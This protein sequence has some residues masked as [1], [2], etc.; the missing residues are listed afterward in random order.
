MLV[1][2]SYHH[3]FTWSDNISRGIQSVLAERAGGVQLRFEFMDTKHIYGEDH[4]QELRR[5]YTLKYAQRPV[6]V[7]IASDDRALHFMLG[8]GQE[9]FPNVPVVFCSVSGYEPSMRQGREITGAEESIDIKATLDIALHLHPGTKDVAVIADMTQTGRAIKGK[10]EKAFQAYTSRLRFQYLEDLTINELKDSVSGLS[11]ETIVFLFFFTHDKV[12][13]VFAPEESLELLAQHCDVP[14][15][16]VWKN[17]LGHGIVGGMLT[18]GEAEGRL[19][20]EMALRILGGERASDIPLEK[21]PTQYMFDH[22]R[23]EQFDVTASLLPAG[24]LI[25]NKPCPFYEAHQGVIWIAISVIVILGIAVVVLTGN[26]VLRRRA[27][28][29]IVKTRA[30]LQAVIEQSPVPMITASPDGT[31]HIYNRAALETLGIGDET[32]FRQGPNILEHEHTWQGFDS[33][34]KPVPM[35]D[36]A[37]DRAVVGE[38]TEAR[39]MRIVR[40]DGTERWVMMEGGPVRDAEGNLLAGFTIFPDITERKQAQEAIMK[41]KHFSETAINSLPG[42]FYFFDGQ[43]RFLRW[44]KNFEYVSGY[45][46]EEIANMTVLNFFTDEDRDLTKQAIQ[47]VLQEGKSSVENQLRRKDG[48][49]IPYYFTG[50]RVTIEGEAFVVGTGIDITERKRTEALVRESEEKYRLLVDHAGDAIFIIQDGMI[51]FPNP[52][53]LEVSGYSSEE[54]QDVPFWDLVH[55][56]DRDTVLERHSRRLAEEEVPAVYSFRIINRKGEELWVEVNV[57]LITWNGRPAT[58]NFV[59]D[60]TAQKR[61]EDQLRQAQKME[62]IGTLAGGIAHDFNNVLAAIIGYTE[63]SLEDVPK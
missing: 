21:S 26:I 8:Y 54:L 35:Q 23:L 60:I 53:T 27:E 5:L 7:V 24:S 48:E 40:Q 20:G 12:G 51:Q 22:A 13:R 16:G 43:G 9:I 2:H 57:I 47:K 39:E 30:L 41:E 3:G 58:L 61:L 6:D 37:L 15:Y 34:G 45:S 32:Y 50:R 31:V 4:L 18:S 33:S 56:E 42:L 49:R 46:S 63:M 25:V 36:L 62:A 10:A 29:E 55:P 11:E 19:A 44:N 38:A 52:K 28:A 1:L 14:I 59:R 17:L